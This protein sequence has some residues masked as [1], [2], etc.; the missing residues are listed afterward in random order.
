MRCD[1][2]PGWPVALS[3]WLM[4][5]LSPNGSKMLAQRTTAFTIVINVIT[6]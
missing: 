6:I 2:R 5:A 1:W 4:A 3:E